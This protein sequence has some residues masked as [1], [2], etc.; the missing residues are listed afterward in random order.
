MSQRRGLSTQD[1]WRHN[2]PVILTGNWEPLIFRRRVG[3]GS[4]DLAE[5]YRQEH[6]E[7][8][9]RRLKESGINLVITHYFKGF[10]L[11]AEAEDIEQAR[12]LIRLCHRQGI[13]VG[14]YIGDTMILETFLAEEPDAASWHQ[15]GPDGTG[16]HYGG[17][18]TFRFKW[19]RTNPAFMAYMK[20]L[21]TQAL[22]DGLDLIHFDNYLDKPEPLSCHCRW[23]TEAFRQFLS[24]TLSKVERRERLGFADVSRVVPP[25]FSAPL[26]VQWGADRVQNPLLQE[27]VN[28]RCH[29]ISDRYRQLAE[30]C[31][32]LNPAV[33]IECNPTG[34][35]GENTAYMRG[36]DHGTLL[37]H[38]E[39]F[40]DESPNPY[41]LLGNGALCTHVRSM[42]LAEPLGTRVFYY[43]A[44]SE[45]GLAEGLA[46]NRGCLGMV[47][48]MLGDRVTVN[49]EVSGDYIR[50]LREKPDLFCRSRS[51]ARVAVCRSYASLAWNSVE[52]QVQAI[53]AEQVLLE[54]HIPFDIVVTLRELTCGVLI[55]PGSECLGSAEITALK[56][57]VAQ[58]GFVILTGTA[59]EYDGWRR[60]W[61]KDPFAGGTPG[62]GRFIRV[63][64]L[65]LPAAAPSL[66]QRVVWDDYYKVIDGRFWI[67]PQNAD[68]LLDALEKT[69]VKLMPYGV[70][71]PRTTLVEPRMMDDGTMLI[72]IVHADPR[73]R[74][75]KLHFSLAAG[76]GVRRVSW[77]AP[78]RE[79]RPLPLKADGRK[80]AFAVTTNATYGLILLR[81][82]RKAP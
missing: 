72:H 60:R 11:K 12:R 66:D 47:G 32:S 35:W 64:A 56:G 6:S 19:C 26:Y 7:A 8:L 65:E 50:L 67:L 3:G 28:F 53:L 46:F 24:A 42:K 22:D 40:W 55:L 81:P 54:N 33:A 16:I 21:I 58:G 4:T 25:V 57:F 44:E 18:Q 34:I 76:A 14:G 73:G 1:E 69:R 62:K 75:K 80:L 15:V 27:W 39:F 77:L 20:R 23:C 71:A 13:R 31:R 41:G 29:I 70:R 37:P 74:R 52:P 78:A 63:P 68:V 61:P 5:L 30:F 43:S 2:G 36:V 51:L 10:G 45:L 49:Q 17:V 38:G 48:G 9:V 79:E 82:D 59:G